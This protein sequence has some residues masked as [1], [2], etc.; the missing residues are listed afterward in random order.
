M[1]RRVKSGFGIGKCDAHPCVVELGLDADHLP[2]LLILRPE[3]IELGGIERTA[4]VIVV[5][6]D[7][8]GT[9]G[10]RMIV[11]LGDSRFRI[12]CICNHGLLATSLPLPSSENNENKSHELTTYREVV[13]FWQTEGFG[14]EKK[15]ISI[16]DVKVVGNF[17]TEQV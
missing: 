15:K 6:L 3:N 1:F 12:H 14:W 7:D 10:P 13:S 2:L 16:L 11:Q 4:S 9:L 5:L 17:V 8:S